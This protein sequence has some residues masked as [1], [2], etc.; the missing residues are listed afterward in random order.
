MT[1]ISL[2]SE[3]VG[4]LWDNSDNTAKQSIKRLI[5]KLDLNSDTAGDDIK[6]IRIKCTN[7]AT[8]SAN[9]TDTDTHYI[10]NTNI[11]IKIVSMQ[12][13]ITDNPIK[14]STIQN[15]GGIVNLKFKSLFT[16][17]KNTYFSFNGGNNCQFSGYGVL[18][19]ND[20]DISTNIY[21]K[22]AKISYVNKDNTADNY[23]QSFYS[24]GNNFYLRGLELVLLQFNTYKKL[25]ETV[26][27]NSSSTNKVYGYIELSNA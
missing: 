8:V 26:D 6:T 3:A 27:I 14:I 17:N 11:G 10:S 20:K 16:E 9:S 5:I 24:V 21:D 18:D 22:S 19:Y 25:T 2:D 15:M 1:N 23:T 13:Y 4:K 7:T 12:E